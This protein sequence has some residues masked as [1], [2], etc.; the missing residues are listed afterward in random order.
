M[1]YL[2]LVGFAAVTTICVV[3]ILG[4]VRFANEDGKNTTLVIP[5]QDEIREYAYP[6]NERGNLMGQI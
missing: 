2:R 1:K 6:V 5:S 3:S 4:I